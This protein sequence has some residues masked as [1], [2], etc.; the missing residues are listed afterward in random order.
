MLQIQ[1]R[2]QQARPTTTEELST[3]LK[4]TVGNMKVFCMDCV[5]DNAKFLI[6]KQVT[7]WLSKIA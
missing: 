1:L 6:H 4:P 3:V 7:R 2:R 5:I